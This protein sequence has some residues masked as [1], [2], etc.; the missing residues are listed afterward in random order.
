MYFACGVANPHLYRAVFLDPPPEDDG[1]GAGSYE[2]LVALVRRCV[3][4]G[5]FPAAQE[6]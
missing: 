4:G 5:R 3:I 2:R 6:S 1:L